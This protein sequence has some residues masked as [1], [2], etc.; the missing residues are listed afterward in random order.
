MPHWRG[1]NFCSHG[2]D[3]GNDPVP[4]WVY[5]AENPT[6]ELIKIG[7]TRQLKIRMQLLSSGKP[8]LR[9]LAVEPGFNRLEAAR[10]EMFAG[11]RTRSRSGQ[12]WEWF[13]M[14]PDLLR[15]IASLREIC[16]DP[17]RLLNLTCRCQLPPALQV[18]A[19][20]P[21]LKQ[22][23]EPWLDVLAR[24]GHENYSWYQ[25]VHPFARR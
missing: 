14:A 23:T 4:C 19:G 17:A 5:Y 25:L 15:H 12:P 2:P 10:H 22:E 6:T 16:G 11:C 3:D 7:T 21:V 13:A 8:H 9:L 1:V 24:I 18:V 20:E